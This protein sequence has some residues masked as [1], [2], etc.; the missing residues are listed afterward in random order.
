MIYSKG[1][2]TSLTDK[3]LLK[4]SL[5]INALNNVLWSNTGDAILLRVPVRY[6]LYYQTMREELMSNCQKLLITLH[7]CR[8][9][10][11][12]VTSSS[13]YYKSVLYL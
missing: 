6:P 10:M 13:L 1:S 9:K 8:V 5:G 12:N 4:Y 2:V 3:D 7:L 11:A